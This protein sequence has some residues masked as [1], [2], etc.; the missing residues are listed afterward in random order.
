LCVLIVLIV[1]NF[2]IIVIPLG[3]YVAAVFNVDCC[4]PP[5]I[6]CTCFIYGLCGFV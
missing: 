3:I 2:Q 4:R 5:C 6:N 1:F